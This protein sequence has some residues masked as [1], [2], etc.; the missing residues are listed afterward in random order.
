M[1]ER[2]VEAALAGL[3]RRP[4]TAASA[5]A[6]SHAAAAGGRTASARTT[7]GSARAAPHAPPRRRVGLAERG[8]EVQAPADFLLFRALEVQRAGVDGQQIAVGVAGEALGQ[9]GF[10]F[11]GDGREGGDGALDLGAGVVGRQPQVL[12]LQRR[13]VEAQLQHALGLFG[14]AGVAAFDAGDVDRLAGAEVIDRHVRRRDGGVVQ[15][16]NRRRRLFVGPAEVDVERGPRRP[17]QADGVG[18]QPAEVGQVL[19]GQVQVGR[20]V[21]EHAQD[22]AVAAGDGQVEIARGAGAVARQRAFGE[23]AGTDA[24][25]VQRLGVEADLEGRGQGARRAFP[26]VAVDDGL[27]IGPAG[28]RPGGVERRCGQVAQIAKGIDGPGR[29]PGLQRRRVQAAPGAGLGFGAIIAAGHRPAPVAQIAVH[30]GA[31][32]ALQGV[33]RA[34]QGVRRIQIALH[35]EV[36]GVRREGAGGRQVQADARQ[37]LIGQPRGVFQ[38][39]AQRQGHGV[40][41]VAHQRPSDGR[42]FLLGQKGAVGGRVAVFALDVALGLEQGGVVLVFQ[43]QRRA[44]LAGDAQDIAFQIADRAPALIRAAHAGLHG[45]RAEVGLE[46]EVHHALIGAIA[47]GEGGFLGQDLGAL[48]AFGRDAADFLEARDAPAVDQKDRRAAARTARHRLQQG[49]Q[50]LDAA[51][52]IGLQLFLIQHQFGFIVAQGR[53]P[54]AARHDL[55]LAQVIG[56]LVF[57]HRRDRG[58][59]LGGGSRRRRLRIG[60]E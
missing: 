53:A 24:F 60:I 38:A 52:A 31:D 5:A 29:H 45:H 57:G 10:Q 36:F 35:Q 30:Q 34:R 16:R 50:L 21:A 2:D 20:Q 8:R 49:H 15:L 43:I 56:V 6:H 47:V 12:V 42:L 17:V 14:Q 3:H 22:L 25:G 41:Q 48:D 59:R 27:D 40:V 28:H 1:I 9:G 23:D 39:G 26:G 37:A 44:L 55:N 7:A 13:Q 11:R 46:D 51:G 19:I 54:A 58:L 32:L 18:A 4:T 33:G